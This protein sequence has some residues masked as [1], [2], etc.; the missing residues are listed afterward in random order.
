MT[1]LRVPK[2]PN[3]PLS[4]EAPDRRYM[5]DLTNTQRLYYNQLDAV[6]AALL[7]PRGGK[8]LD[9]PY[10]SVSRTTDRAFVAN[11]TTLVTFDTNDFLN[12][13]TNPGTGGIVVEQAG[14]YN[15][16]FSVQ[17]ANTDT[18]IHAAWIWLRAGGVDVPGTASKFDI[19]GKHGSGD[20][21][22]IA[23][24]NFYV[25]LQ[26]GQEVQMA[27]A[28]ANAAVY[29]DARAAQ[30][31]PFVM[32]AIPSVVATLSFVSNIPA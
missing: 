7:S 22:L 6:N 26:Q 31:A 10:A 25:Q 11:T 13:C 12:G 14:V 15:Y 27:A 8:W 24:A 23:A 18:Q 16:Q 32:P 29:M 20:G 21:Y 5:D 2:A 28:A 30:V 19:P 4:P 1:Q 9:L 17:F 3:L